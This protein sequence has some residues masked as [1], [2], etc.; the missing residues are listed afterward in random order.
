MRLCSQL[1]WT[2][3][4]IN[5]RQY[6]LE[7]FF[8]ALTISTQQGRGHAA[9]WLES[10]TGRSHRSTAT[11]TCDRRVRRLSSYSELLQLSQF[12]RMLQDRWESYAKPTF[13]M[14]FTEHIFVCCLL[15]FLMPCAA[16]LSLLGPL[17]LYPF[18]SPPR[19]RQVVGRDG[20]AP[21]AAHRHLHPSAAR[22]DPHH[23]QRHGPPRLRSNPGPDWAVV[24]RC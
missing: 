2:W 21:D 6:Q 14:L 3:G 24:A 12:K 23:L 7:P 13:I 10:Q 19:P 4:P 20:Y 9:P 5:A 8:K 11:T 16:A 15:T 17:R 18:L 22:R 1:L